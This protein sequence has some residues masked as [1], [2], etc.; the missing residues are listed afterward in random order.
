MKKSKYL[1]SCI[2]ATLLLTASSSTTFAATETNTMT[3]SATTAA[4]GC[5]LGNIANLNFP[6]ID[7]ANLPSSPY[8]WSNPGSF[9]VTCPSGQVYT[10]AIDNGIN[11]GLTSN[12]HAGVMIEGSD[13]TKYI[14]YLLYNTNS[15]AGTEWQ[16]PASF[17]SDG[18]ERMHQVY[19]MII[20]DWL[21]NAGNRNITPGAT[22]ADTV[23]ITLSF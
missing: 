20:N 13:N 3:V 6:E 21:I 1:L 15:V 8:F 9:A 11:S 19:A 22:L 12:T 2:S 4:P 5:T 14:E 17:T 10:A 23:T 16:T 7:F 18:T